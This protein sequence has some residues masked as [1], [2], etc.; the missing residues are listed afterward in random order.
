[1]ELKQNKIFIKMLK[2]LSNKP[3]LD[4][5]KALV[6]VRSLHIASNTESTDGVKISFEKYH[7][8]RWNDADTV[9]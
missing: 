1:M 8:S 2:A 7:S 5:R 9:H 3:V 6:P 4:L